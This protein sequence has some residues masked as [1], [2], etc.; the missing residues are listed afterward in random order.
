MS[1]EKKP[2]FLVYDKEIAL[3]FNELLSKS[4]QDE[5]ELSKYSSSMRVSVSMKKYHKAL[6][7]GM[8]IAQENN[9]DISW[10]NAYNI[11][12]PLGYISV[13]YGFL[14]KT[15]EADL[16]WELSAIP[17]FC[18][19][20]IKEYIDEL[21]EFL[22]GRDIRIKY[23]I[24]NHA[25]EFLVNGSFKDYE[26]IRKQCEEFNCVIKNSP[27]IKI[28]FL[29]KD[30]YLKINEEELKKEEAVHRSYFDKSM[31]AN[32]IIRLQ[33]SNI[34]L[35]KDSNQ[36]IETTEYK[37][38]GSKLCTRDF[39]IRNINVSCL[40][41]SSI[42]GSF[43]IYQE[44]EYESSD[45]ANFE[46][47]VSIL[48]ETTVSIST[49]VNV[50]RNIVDCN[51]DGL[52]ARNCLFYGFAHEDGSTSFQLN[53]YFKTIPTISNGTVLL[54]YSDFSDF[55]EVYELP[56]EL[57]PFKVYKN[58]IAHYEINELLKWHVEDGILDLD[59]PKVFD[60][61]NLDKKDKDLEEINSIIASCKTKDGIT[62]ALKRD[63]SDN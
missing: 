2:V 51:F 53:E 36:S 47:K 12:R 42:Q 10:I 11:P 28:K 29:E 40:T 24:N 49:N 25:I 34:N 5:T 17:D 39:N 8:A 26:L 3:R 31:F 52:N 62:L 43:L 22:S 19:A 33:E 18:P 16:L 27:F 20:D 46:S 63:S 4:L 13:M 41:D 54:H 32:G 58:G 15:R 55:I 7:K 44:K 38:N 30:G 56:K 60:A 50:P 9:W 59:S 14:P 45:I 1:E 35:Q 57:H 6:A 48:D 21:T 61:T 37:D 23:D